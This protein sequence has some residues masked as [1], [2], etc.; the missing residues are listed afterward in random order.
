MGPRTDGANSRDWI[1][2]QHR[3][4]TMGVP[5]RVPLESGASMGSWPFPVYHLGTVV[6]GYEFPTQA[7]SLSHQRDGARIRR[8][9]SARIDRILD[10]YAD[11]WEELAKH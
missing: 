4:L 3:Q 2:A 1:E 10:D 6:A 9:V 8:D 7:P 11:I 5:V